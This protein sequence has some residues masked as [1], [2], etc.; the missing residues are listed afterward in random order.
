[1]ASSTNLNAIK[2]P[3][4][5]KLDKQKCRLEQVLSDGNEFYC[6]T[7]NDHDEHGN[8]NASK[9]LVECKKPTRGDV[10]F[11]YNPMLDEYEDVFLR[12]SK[13]VLTDSQAT[14]GLVDSTW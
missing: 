8:N 13:I 1:M 10:C 9:R 6:L 4:Q 7:E 5:R 14:T 12:G 3:Q 11:R 2:D